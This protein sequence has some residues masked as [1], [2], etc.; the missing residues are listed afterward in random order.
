MNMIE[1][2]QRLDALIVE[3]TKPPVTTML[4]N[5]LSLISEQAEAYQAAADKQ[6]HTLSTQVETIERLMKEKQAIIA[7]QS[8]VE[9]KRF[10][11]GIEF[12]KGR[13]TGGK[14]QPFCPKCR[15]PVNDVIAP[16]GISRWALCSMHCGWVGVELDLKGGMDAVIAEIGK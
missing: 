2:I 10:H 15:L 12:R 14:W 11:R 8:G 4:R 9:E 6:D 3:H 1:H 16:T 5:E 7:A 13:R